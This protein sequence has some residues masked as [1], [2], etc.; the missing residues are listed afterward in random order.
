ML[1]GN[2]GIYTANPGRYFGGRYGGG[3]AHL[4]RLNTIAHYQ[5]FQTEV[6]FP[7][8]GTFYT[9]L[10][11]HV[12]VADFAN[13]GINAYGAGECTG[14]ITLG[15]IITGVADGVST[16]IGAGSVILTG[17]GTSEGSCEISGSVE[18]I[19]ILSGDAHGISAMS[20]LTSAN[21]LLAGVAAGSSDGSL[22][23]FAYG[24]MSG[25]ASAGTELSP[26]ALAASVWNSLLADYANSGTMG[27][28]MNSVSGGGA[29]G[30]LTAEEHALLVATAKK[31]DIAPL[32]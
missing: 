11:K 23:P 13:M 12:D 7:I 32:Y 2:Q 14:A 5:A 31:T 17:A 19:G 27:E 6:G 25:V 3:P 8:S 28:R 24:S 30:G 1:L 18:G 15:Y 26:D 9:Q 22:A 16:V 4:G 10:F 29:S 20:S 21:A